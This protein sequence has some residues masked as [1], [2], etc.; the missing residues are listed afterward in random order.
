MYQKKAISILA[1]TA[2]TFLLI[3]TV[4]CNSQETFKDET[5]TAENRAE[6]LSQADSQLT[7]EELR[8]LKQY[9]NRSYPQLGENDLPLGR[10]LNQM[11]EEERLVAASSPA[12]Q[13]NA[14]V[15]QDDSAQAEAAETPAKT[16]PAA[17]VPSRPRAAQQAPAQQAPAQQAPAAQAPAQAQAE[18]SAPLETAAPAENVSSTSP[19]AELSAPVSAIPETA[20]PETPQSVVVEVAPGTDIQVRL[21]EPIGTE[22]AQTGDRFELELAQDLVVGDKLIAPKGSRARGRVLDSQ[23]AGKV[24]G[25]ATMSL[26]L[27]DLYI[28][29]EQF[30]LQAETLT[31]QAEKTTGKDATKVGIGT[32]VGAILGAIIGGKKGAAVGAGVGAGAGTATVLATKGDEL[33]FPVEQM[34]RFR[35]TNG[36]KVEVLED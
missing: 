22:T 25:L 7:V 3:F 33:V 8:L 11:I 9:L 16:T 24:K 1:L 21:V 4:S 19:N 28:G 35:L 18:A 34:F 5:I 15:E 17:P 27:T 31:Y 26:T 32:G 29:Q 13:D 20:T 10:T 2:V 14:A 12:Q 6:I 30:P 23:A 36:F